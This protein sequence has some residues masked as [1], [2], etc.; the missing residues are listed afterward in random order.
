MF[1]EFRNAF[2]FKGLPDTRSCYELIYHNYAFLS[3]VF[4]SQLLLDD[5]VSVMAAKVIT[6]FQKLILSI[7]VRYYYLFAELLTLSQFSVNTNGNCSC[8]S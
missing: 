5:C 6:I 3:F 7:T 1:I 4:I 2:K 8:C